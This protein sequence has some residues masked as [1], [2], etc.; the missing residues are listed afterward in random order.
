MSND[1]PNGINGNRE[2]IYAVMGRTFSAKIERKIDHHFSY[3]DGLYGLL[4]LIIITASSFTVTLLPMHNAITTPEFW[5]EIIFSSSSFAFFFPASCGIGAN[6]ALNPFKKRL[7]MVII[8]LFIVY[9]VSF[10]LGFSLI[11]LLWSVIHGYFE[12]FPWRFALL[13]YPVNMVVLTRIWTLIPKEKRRDPVFRQKCLMYILYICWIQF[14]SIQLWGMMLA[15][16]MVS[17]DIQWLIGMSVPLTKEINDYIL[18]KLIIRASISE[19][20][21]AAQD[22]TKIVNNLTYSCWFAILATTA[23][24]ATNFLILGIYFAINMALCLKIIRLNK[25]ISTNDGNLEKEKSLKEEAIKELIFNETIENMIPIAFIGSF[26]TA[27][28]GPN[29]YNL[30]M[31]GCSIWTF[32]KV[33]DFFIYIIPV[34]EMS[35]IDSTSLFVAGV[36]LWWFCKINIFKEYCN[37]IKRYW[38]HV[39]FWG[40]IYMSG[41]SIK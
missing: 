22:M 20:L 33:E 38:I 1:I 29:K 37:T 6:T 26:A 10:A 18:D 40:G 3:L 39:A 23:T 34:V 12:P 14:I 31:A 41:V 25:K 13:T 32:Q 24:M 19:N 9:M 17:P 16:A 30:G 27:Y 2:Q 8:D 4:D 11:H 36:S 28:Y 35:L 21:A 7:W 15:L 5:Y